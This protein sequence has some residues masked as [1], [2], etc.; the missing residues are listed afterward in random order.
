MSSPVSVVVLR[1][2]VR[3]EYGV[4]RTRGTRK[5]RLVVPPRNVLEAFY[6][7]NSEFRVDEGG[8]V[9]PSEPLDYRFELN[10]T[11]QTLLLVLR[12]S[13]TCLLDRTAFARGCIERGMNENTFSIFSSYS[14]IVEHLGTDLWTLRG[15]HV[16][17]ASVEALRAA[18]ASRPRQKRILDYGWTP[19]GSLWMAVR[20]PASYQAGVFGIPSAIQRYVEGRDFAARSED[21][22]LCGT[23]RVGEEGTSW[24]FGPFLSRN[25]ADEDDILVADFDLAN[26]AVTLRLGSDDLL[27][28]Y[29]L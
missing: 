16:D 19:D 26:D 22:S 12:S 17:P 9:S 15:V 23:I 5:W 11:E 25:G 4:R 6:R 27:E 20:L 2:G 29:S 7:A 8:L 3:R 24:G 1:E 14:P 13:P 10:R 21:G 28:E 18:N